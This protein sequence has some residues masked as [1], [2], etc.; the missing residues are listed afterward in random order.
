MKN[1]N[2][3]N[4]NRKSNGCSLEKLSCCNDADEY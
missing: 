4:I 3:K 1:I 2:R